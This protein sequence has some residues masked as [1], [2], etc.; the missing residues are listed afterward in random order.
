[1][2]VADAQ[3]RV[4]VR[5]VGVLAERVDEEENRRDPA[6]GDLRGDLRVTSE[7]AGEH[8]FDVEADFLVESPPVVPV[9]IR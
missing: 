8:P 5:V 6:F 1:M 3:Q 9:P 4:D 2:D 7:R